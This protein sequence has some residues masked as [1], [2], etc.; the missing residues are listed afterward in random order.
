MIDLHVGFTGGEF[1]GKP[2]E[3]Y[4]DVAMRQVDVVRLAMRKQWRAAAGAQVGT[5]MALG[6]VAARD[7][8]AWL[9]RLRSR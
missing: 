9:D 6:T 1:G 2:P 7:A 3:G 4:F 5:W 8:R